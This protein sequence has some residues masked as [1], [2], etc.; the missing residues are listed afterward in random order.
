MREP[1]PY[2]ELTR[3]LRKT[4]PNDRL[5]QDE[6]RLFACST[7]ASF[8][9]LV[10][11]LI[12]KVRSEEEVV[13]VMSACDRLNLPF[14]FRSAGT[15]L[16][17]QAV[18][19]SVLIQVDRLWNETEI[20]DEGK[21]IR[22]GPAVVG[23]EAN[24]VLAPFARKIGPDPASVDS[25]M[26][27]GIAANNASGMCC[28]NVQDTYHTLASARIILADGA[29]LDT[30]SPQSREE[31]CR[32]RGV[33]VERINRL[34]KR[35]K[36]DSGL[37]DL[38]RRKYRIKNTTGYSLHALIDFDDPIDII[39][40]L[41]IGSE[42]TL[43]FF[44]SLTFNTVP[45]H[46]SRATALVG[47]P[48][49]YAACLISARLGDAGV[50]AAVELMDGQS[51]RAVDAKM[52]EVV[53][54][55][56]NLGSDVCALLVEVRSGS[57]AELDR[58]VEEAIELIGVGDVLR[59]PEFTREKIRSK[60]LWEI[61]KGLFPSLGYNR[62]Q[63]T[64]I[65]IEDVAFPLASLADGAV[66]LRRL[67]DRYG[68]TDAVI[69]GHALQGNLHFVFCVNLQR[70][71]EVRNYA[72]FLD[73]LVQL[74]T[75]K[76]G[77]S[78]KAEHGTG[79]NMAPFV[80]AEWGVVAVE[81]MREIKDAFD[82][83]GLLNPG[84][85]LSDDQRIHV[86]NLKQT[87][88]SHPII[89]KCTECGFCERTCPSRHLTLT[90]RQRI[91]AWREICRVGSDPNESG[92]HE[93]LLRDFDY[94]GDQTCA[95]DGLCGG[96]CPV[97]INT[98]SFIKE[99]RRAEHS[100]ASELIADF[101]A[102]NFGMVLK[103]T[104]AVLGAAH[105]VRGVVGDEGMRRLTRSLRGMVGNSV[106]EWNRWLPRAAKDKPL[107]KDSGGEG[108]VYFPSCVSRVFGSSIGGRYPESQRS[109][110]DRLIRSAGLRPIYPRHVSDLCCGMA[111]SSKGFSRQAEEKREDLLASLLAAS[112]NGRHP[113]VFDTSPCTQ[114]TREIAIESLGFT[115]YDLPEFISSVVAPRV[116][117]KRVK[118]TVAV[119]VPCSLKGKAGESELLRLARLCADDVFVPN[120][121]PC[122][123]FAGD[124]GFSHPELPASA[125]V[126]LPRELPR[127]CVAGYS[128]SRT[129]EIG[130]SLHSGI[131]Y[132]SI[133]F[134]VDEA[135]E[136]PH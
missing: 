89:E 48:D 129:C 82:P 34:A 120:S 44:S 86:S 52:R 49:M 113:V 70:E 55:V 127:V 121:V 51:L 135:I 76:Y 12:L 75:A 97:G 73:D 71:A 5:I 11:K 106:P 112:E 84:V 7:D 132:Q 83:K 39:E 68:F 100:K 114:R 108:V 109:C 72:Q 57:E 125:L 45:D 118:G 131:S 90:P 32:G 33:L 74:V 13:A 79:R 103:L 94:Y 81:I 98:G 16:S 17:G 50:A 104:R 119:H 36:G 58:D 23:S 96:A 101:T 126:T 62:P 122:C 14:T 128:T 124:R 8:Y 63:G 46:P 38:I 9:R 110:V 27:A 80:K 77:G 21:Q 130:V 88:P 18:S 40:H 35:V 93:E 28:G 95:V 78:L 64:T 133:A 67:L 66:D 15:S 53:E 24:R 92:R 85:I 20:D 69:F 47:C 54:G 60:Q 37:S 3:I 31:F 10:P 102:K 22:C 136:K 2:D 65:I 42:G 111:F 105:T 61:R 116:T 56:D 25:A 134:L 26:V 99:L 115:V 41:L 107:T 1:S 87:P 59:P 123:G 6:L 91:A 43:G 30:G 4:I 29:I 19:D 117:L